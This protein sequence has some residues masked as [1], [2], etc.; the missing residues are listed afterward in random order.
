MTAKPK[1]EVNTKLFEQSNIKH[2]SCVEKCKPDYEEVFNRC[3]KINNTESHD[4]ASKGF[5][6]EL[7]EDLINTWH[8]ILLSCFIAF[9]FSYS[10]L[11]L[12][13]YAI[14]YVI[15]I[16]YGGF[17]ALFAIG[18]LVCWIFAGI[19]YSKNQDAS[20]MV[21]AGVLTLIAL[22]A[23][24]ILLYFRS[25]IK[26]VAKLFKEASRALVDV[27]SILFEPVL[28]FV[29]LILAFVPFIIFLIVIQTTG[30]PVND[31]NS[32]DS[33]HVTY[34]SDG[35]ATFAYILNFISFYWFVQFIFGCQHFI[36]AGRLKVFS[37]Y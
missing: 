22:L 20:L 33:V 4:E 16:I 17:V 6:N 2:Y 34:K 30:E 9:I 24:G 14:K 12:F 32:D 37:F 19:Q 26:L 28:T 31:R 1:V 7:S 5:F 8:K 18:A 15:W 29:S 35:V 11:M 23:V 13:R 27:P 3:V 36:I 10:V 21:P 25:R